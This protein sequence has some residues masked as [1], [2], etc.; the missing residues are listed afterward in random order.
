MLISEYTNLGPSTSRIDFVGEAEKDGKTV[1][2]IVE[3]QSKLPSDDDIKR[4][5][6]YV[7]SLRIF[8]NNNVVLFILCTKKASYDKKEFIINDECIYTMHMVSL[9]DFKARE[10]FKNI[11]DKIKNNESI[12]DE[13]IASLQVIVYTDTDESELEVLLK[14]RKLIERI[15]EYS[16]MSINEKSAIAYLFNVL[17]A[18]MLDEDDATKFEEETYMLLN[19]M[20]RYCEAKGRREGRRDGMK[21]GIKRGKRE[22]AKNMLKKGFDMGEVMEITGLSEEEILNG[23]SL[24]ESASKI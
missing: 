24:E 17:S 13:D 19:P 12:T 15:A 18:N 1:S 21:D 20:D 22:T 9:K 7:S 5:F 3:C 8:K 6:Q 2:L 4:F 16:E 10:I 11:E 14:A 23:N